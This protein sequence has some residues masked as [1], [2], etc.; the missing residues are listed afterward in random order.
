MLSNNNICEE[1][2]NTTEKMDK[3]VSSMGFP[4]EILAIIPIEEEATAIPERKIPKT[5]EFISF[6]IIK[7]MP[8]HKFFKSGNNRVYQC[9]NA[10]KSILFQ[11]T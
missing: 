9:F 11:V 3:L 8:F 10:V 4:L 1:N 6:L 2:R 7:Q 5:G